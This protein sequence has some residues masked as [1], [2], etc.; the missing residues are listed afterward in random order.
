LRLGGNEAQRESGEAK[1]K[2]EEEEHVTSKGC[3]WRIF[4]KIY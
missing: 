3:E 4:I 2:V 1:T